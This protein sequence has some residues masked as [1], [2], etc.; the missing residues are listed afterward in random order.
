MHIRIVKKLT[1]S[2]IDAGVDHFQPGFLYEVDSAIALLFVAEGWAELVGPEEPGLVGTNLPSLKDAIA[3][4]IA[5][6]DAIASAI[7][8]RTPRHD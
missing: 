2:S 7:E 8:R 4:D 1:P 3:A 6:D 5:F